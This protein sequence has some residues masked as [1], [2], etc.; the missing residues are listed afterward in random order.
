MLLRLTLCVRRP[1]LA[2]GAFFVLLNGVAMKH[3]TANLS[4]FP[5]LRAVI[6]IFFA[7]FNHQCRRFHHYLVIYCWFFM[8]FP[9]GAFRFFSL[10]SSSLFS[11]IRRCINV[12][13]RTIFENLVAHRSPQPWKWSFCSVATSHGIV[14]KQLWTRLNQF[15]RTNKTRPIS[16]NAESGKR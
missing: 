16:E 7:W 8:F 11:F 6:T 15:G 14:C 10:P 12:K 9:C 2:F 13:V 3:L 1:L 5:E 4:L